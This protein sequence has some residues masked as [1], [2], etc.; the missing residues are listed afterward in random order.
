SLGSQQANSHVHWHIAP[1]P[2]GVPFDKQQLNAIR[3]SN[4]ILDMSDDEMHDLANHIRM[5]IRPFGF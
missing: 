4:G 2:Y 5:G 3:F 1:L